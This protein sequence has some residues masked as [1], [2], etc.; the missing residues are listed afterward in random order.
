MTNY[1][2]VMKMVSANKSVTGAAPFV[3]GQVLIK[4]E[5]AEGHPMVS[6]P[7]VRGIEPKFET[8]LSLLATNIVGEFDLT[9]D[10]V[11]VGTDLAHNLR[12]QLGERIAVY[13]PRNLEQMEKQRGKTNEEAILPE[14]FVVRGIFDVGYSEYNAGVIVTS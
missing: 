6:A 1:L 14:E 7:W 9:G 2:A 12:L 3:M 8:N 10:S 5:P 11:L 4:S 13:S